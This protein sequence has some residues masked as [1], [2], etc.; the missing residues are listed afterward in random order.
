[1]AVKIDD[2]IPPPTVG[3]TYNLKRSKSEKEAEFD[4]LATIKA[5]KKAL[6]DAG[7]NVKLLEVNKSLPKKL[8]NSHLDII[9]NIAEGANGRSREAQVPALLDFYNLKFTGSDATTL[10]VCLDKALTK[11]VVM[12]GGI[13][14]PGFQVIK[15]E[16][17]KLNPGLKFP[18][19]VKPNAEGS[20][21][22]ISKISVVNDAAE[23]K[24]V[25]L[26]LWDMYKQPILVEEY[27]KGREFTV[28]VLGNGDDLN[29]LKP[30]EV[31][32]LQKSDNS[33]YDYSVKQDYDDKV[34]YVCPA[35]L[36]PM[37]EAVMTNA[38]RDIFNILDCK[39][40]ARID[41]RLSD[42]NELHFIE[43]NPLPGLAPGYSDLPMLAESNGI[44][45]DELV[46][47]ILQNALKRYGMDLE[48]L[49]ADAS[50][51][52]VQAKK[53]VHF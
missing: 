30:M 10:S 31:E 35:C 32:F 18:L 33:I 34:N 19:I 9:F 37:E 49:K 2:K 38:A 13:K 29:V 25:V 14:T 8:V 22:G 46:K 20:S 51:Q 6:N 39:D 15:S 4:S 24:I 52:K 7:Y 28:G 5:I 48:K 40:V 36:T 45:Y 16:N 26:N 12:S 41:F 3:F 42:D 44:S 53:L 50:V 1:M 17:F 11:Q 27:I 47:I 21:K 23:L 43:I